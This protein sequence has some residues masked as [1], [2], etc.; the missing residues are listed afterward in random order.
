MDESAAQE[1]VA[2]SY[3]YHGEE[4]DARRLGLDSGGMD[5]DFGTSFSPLSTYAEEI[6]AVR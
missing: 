2:L 1:R 4:D 5:D 6:G 3:W